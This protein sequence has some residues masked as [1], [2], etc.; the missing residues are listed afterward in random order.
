MSPLNLTLI[1]ILKFPSA[2]F[3]VGNLDLSPHLTVSIERFMGIQYM[4]TK[5]MYERVG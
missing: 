2:L 3:E 1:I 4:F 5:W